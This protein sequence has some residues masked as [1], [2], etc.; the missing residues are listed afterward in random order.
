MAIAL[1]HYRAIS[2]ES[3]GAIVCSW[4]VYQY[5]LDVSSRKQRVAA[6]YLQ[7]IGG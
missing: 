4:H 3:D 5:V 1:V 7:D 6:R 2:F